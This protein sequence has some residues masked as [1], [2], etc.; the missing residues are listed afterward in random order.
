MT[1]RVL[2]PL[3]SAITLS[4]VWGWV[5]VMLQ[6]FFNVCTIIVTACVDKNQSLRRFD[7]TTQSNRFTFVSSLNH[8]H[9]LQICSHTRFAHTECCH[10]VSP[11]QMPCLQWR[12]SLVRCCMGTVVLTSGLHLSR[13]LPFQWIKLRQLSGHMTC[14]SIV[15][16]LYMTHT[17][18]LENVLLLSLPN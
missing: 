1:P 7:T 17:K 13:T 12:S 5:T 3:K 9:H 10:Y 18:V 16:S 6:L 4:Q 15:W 14:Q 11:V 2:R 8:P